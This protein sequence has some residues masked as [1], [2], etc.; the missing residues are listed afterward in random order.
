MNCQEFETVIIDLARPAVAST[1]ARERGRAHVETCARCAARLADERA[2]GAGLRA[3]GA[4]VNVPSPRLE[5]ALLMAFRAQHAATPTAAVPASLLAFTPRPPRRRV[6]AMAAAVVV[7]AFVGLIA[8]SMLRSSPTASVERTG[9]TPQT[10][11]P[12]PATESVAPTPTSMIKVAKVDERGSEAK[13]RRESS[14]PRINRAS[15]GSSRR[16]T[17]ARRDAGVQTLAA[18]TNAPAVAA[19]GSIATE[20][21]PLGGGGGLSGM[22]G[23]QIVRVEVPRSALASFGLPVDA[24]RAGGRVKADVVLGHDGVARAIRFVR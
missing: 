15:G 7:A 20:F 21:M 19:E 24:E 9:N 23:G 1:A 22:D 5:T 3:A 11:T 13:D 8:L 2:L 6:Y 18:S 4:D 17:R 10:T 12:R 14:S 16:S